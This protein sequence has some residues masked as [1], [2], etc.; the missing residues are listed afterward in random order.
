MK[1][2]S[3]NRKLIAWLALDALAAPEAAVLRDHLARCAGCRQYWEDVSSVTDGLSAAA[4]DSNLEASE[5]FHRRVAEKLRAVES[6][7]VLDD[8]AAWARGWL[9]NW[10]VALPVLAMLVVALFAVIA[11]GPHS[12]VSPP[13]PLAAQAASKSDS[14]SDLAPTLANYQM[15]AQESLEKLSDLLTRQGNQSLPPAPVYTVSGL[16]PAKVPF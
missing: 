10:R 9:L 6:S 3:R 2:C 13:P 1:P 4:P 16:E 12:A 8:L 11:F 14:R 15:V 5:H 7:S